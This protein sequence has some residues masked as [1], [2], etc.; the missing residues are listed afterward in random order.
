MTD[1]S[2]RDTMK[3]AT[4]PLIASHGSVGALCDQE[5]TL[6]DEM[7]EA[8]ADGGGT[9]GI[10]FSM[11]FLSQR[12]RDYVDLEDGAAEVT[13]DELRVD[14]AGNHAPWSNAVKEILA[15]TEDLTTL[16]QVGVGKRQ[17]AIGRSFTRWTDPSLTPAGVDVTGSTTGPKLQAMFD[18]NRDLD[19][20]PVRPAR[21]MAALPNRHAA[22]ASPASSARFAP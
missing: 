12:H 6:T 3:V 8:T 13:L 15:Q 20:P 10:N 18:V 14:A 19:G 7:I 11:R 4:K 9:I 16:W 17:T 5:R 2:F 22:C 1:E 21:V